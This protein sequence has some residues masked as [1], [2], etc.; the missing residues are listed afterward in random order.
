MCISKTHSACSTT[1]CGHKLRMR[2][3]IVGLIVLI[4]ASAGA[5]WYSMQPEPPTHP[6]IVIEPQVSEPVSIVAENLDIPWDIAF[7]PEGG[8]L[9]TERTGSLLHIK[10]DKSVTEVPL[11]RS[12]VRGEGGLLGIVLHPNFKN[13]RFVYLYMSAQAADGTENRVERYR[14]E[15]S[16]LSD[17]RLIIGGIPGATYHDGGRMAFGP[18]GKL[19]ITTGDATRG[20]IAQ[21]KSSLGG[22]ILRLNDDGS[23]TSDNP[24]GSAV[25][26]YG[27]RNPQ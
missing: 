15:N 1:R 23:V 19:Y 20:Q 12:E 26:S 24:F 21:D 18:D 10:Q 6:P 2:K 3:Y 11:K 22:K 13:S 9:V 8:M 4:A 17:E 16:T 5:Y 27:D 14:F 25:W 7:L